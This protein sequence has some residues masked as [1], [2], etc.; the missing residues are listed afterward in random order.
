MDAG[1]GLTIT[2]VDS[3]GC[4]RASQTAGEEGPVEGCR[5]LSAGLPLV[6]QVGEQREIDHGEG[7]ISET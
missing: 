1:Q 4:S 3:H 2:G 5:F 6:I 7:N